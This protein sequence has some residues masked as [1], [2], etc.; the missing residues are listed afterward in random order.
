M[1]LIVE[2]GAGLANS[3]SYVTLAEYDAYAAARGYSIGGTDSHKE[4]ELT[5]AM[6]YLESYRDKFKGVK[7]R[8]DQSLQWPRVGVILDGFSIGSNV[9]PTELKRAQMEL[10]HLSATVNLMPSG[11]FQDVASQQLDTM[12]ISF[13]QGG[14]YKM[15][16]HKSVDALLYPLLKLAGGLKAIRV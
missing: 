10:A 13:H 7:L 4:V 16:Q 8:Q 6:D 9:I 3:N 14:S 5:K 2:T 11:E 12:A 1:A 15:V